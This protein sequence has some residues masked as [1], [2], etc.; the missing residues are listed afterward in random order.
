[1][2]LAECALSLTERFGSIFVDLAIV[3]RYVNKK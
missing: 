2:S 3:L 1:L